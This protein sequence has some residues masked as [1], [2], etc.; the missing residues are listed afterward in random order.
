MASHEIFLSQDLKNIIV[1]LVIKDN[2]GTI[3]IGSESV[4]WKFNPSNQTFTNEDNQTISYRMEGKKMI[5][6]DS[7]SRMVFEKQ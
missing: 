1:D 2:V 5:I 6:E 4:V 3:S 7:N